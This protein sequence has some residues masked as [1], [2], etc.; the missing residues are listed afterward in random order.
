ML[1]KHR[2][3]GSHVNNGTWQGHFLAIHSNLDEWVAWEKNLGMP[4]AFAVEPLIV[5]DWE[6]SKSESKS[7]FAL[8][9]RPFGENMTSPSSRYLSSFFFKTLFESGNKK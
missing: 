1:N 4:T 5:I 8:S 7:F 3:L 9:R 2:T 6:F